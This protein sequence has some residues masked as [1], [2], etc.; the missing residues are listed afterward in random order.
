MHID[1]VL[2]A[3][4]AKGAAVGKVEITLEGQVL[5]S[6]NLVALEAVEEGSLFRRLWDGIRLFFFNLFN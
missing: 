1:P 3:P 4:L 6:A 2:V 5:H